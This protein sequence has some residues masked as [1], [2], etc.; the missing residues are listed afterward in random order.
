MF[1]SDMIVVVVVQTI[2]QTVQ[3][4]DSA[5]KSVLEKGEVLLDSVHDPSIRDNLRTLQ[6]DYLLLCDA[7]QVHII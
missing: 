3:S 7:A 1:V 2:L 6:E 4:H 5:L